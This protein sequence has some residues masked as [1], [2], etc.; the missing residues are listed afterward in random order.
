MDAR[1][2]STDAPGEMFASTPVVPR[3]TGPSREKLAV[4]AALSSADTIPAAGIST[5]AASSGWLRRNARSLAA[6]AVILIVGVGIGVGIAFAVAPNADKAYAQGKSEG[7]DIGDTRGYNRGHDAG[8]ESGKSDGYSSGLDAGKTAV[9]SD[10][11]PVDGEFYLVQY[12][13]TGGIAAYWDTPIQIGQCVSINYTGGST[14]S[15][16]S[17]NLSRGGFGC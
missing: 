6:G 13:S 9:F 14:D 3:G 12:D 8:Y 1:T 7:V 10:L 17:Y 16:S 4:T 5:A 15:G 2:G 11:N